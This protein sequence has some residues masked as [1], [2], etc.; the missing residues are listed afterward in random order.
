M[1]KKYHTTGTF[2]KSKRGIVERGK[3]DT[4]NK[5]PTLTYNVVVTCTLENTE[6]QSRMDSPEKLAT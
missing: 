4:H 2:P 3:I 5:M 1:E 6:G